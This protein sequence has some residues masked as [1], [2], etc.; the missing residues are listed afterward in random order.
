MG[1]LF[2]TFRDTAI[3]EVGVD[4]VIHYSI[5]SAFSVPSQGSSVINYMIIYLLMVYTL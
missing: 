5:H 3:G 2:S 1:N 4:T